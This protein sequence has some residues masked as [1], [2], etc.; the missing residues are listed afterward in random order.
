[1]VNLM[2]MIFIF[3]DGF[4]LGEKDSLRNP[5]YAARTPNLDYIFNNY[6][7]FP[8]DASLGIAGLPQSATGQTAIFTGLNAPEVLG[9]HLSGQPTETLKAII[10][11]NNLFKELIRRGLKVTNANV[12]RDEYLK[13]ML[14]PVDRTVR[15]SVTSVMTMSAG[16]TFRMVED[17]R[18][19]MGVYHDI[20]GGIIKDSGY[21]VE[22][23]TP[24]E[25]AERLF[26][27]SL[28]HD[29]TLYE[30][31]MTDIIGH[32]MDMNLAK[33]EI[34]LLDAF[35]GRLFELVNMDEYVIVITSDHGN[36]EDISIKTHTMNKVPVIIAGEPVGNM[37][38][39]VTSLL[40]IM[41]VVLEVFDS[42][43][44]RRA[45]E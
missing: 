5:V 32:S 45:Y 10:H 42:F 12:Y 31:F 23:I 44:T 16:L 6:P 9:R 1:M 18:N 36:I 2:R 27:I 19:G 11:E 37:D 38:I 43:I 8:T 21:D 35:L 3:I 26:R 7:V 28:E 17:Y 34:E 30:H 4:G 39:K 24:E 22:L 29:F 25:A 15:P 13:R 41:P 14:D 40:D 20:T 33:G